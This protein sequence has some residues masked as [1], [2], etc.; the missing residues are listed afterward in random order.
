M[1]FCNST[2]CLFDRICRSRLRGLSPYAHRKYQYSE[3]MEMNKNY[4][5]TIKAALPRRQ[6]TQQRRNLDIQ[7]SILWQPL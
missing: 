2:P 6:Q 3:N 4:M 7:L 5:I 1:P